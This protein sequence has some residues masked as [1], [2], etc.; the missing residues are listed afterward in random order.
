MIYGKRSSNTGNAC[1]VIQFC[2]YE[3]SIAMDDRSR[4]GQT[5]LTRTSLMVLKDGDE[6]TY[7]FA[8]LHNTEN[9]AINDPDGEVLSE[10]M[11]AIVNKTTPQKFYIFSKKTSAPGVKPVCWKQLGIITAPSLM[12]ARAKIDLNCIGFNTEAP[13]PFVDFIDRER[14]MY[15]LEEMP[16]WDGV[17]DNASITEPAVK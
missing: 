16:A 13:V 15:T 12:D 14:V 6:V 10:V 17:F 9:G 7:Q 1:T 2:G 11:Q 4:G 3:I 5:P 8:G